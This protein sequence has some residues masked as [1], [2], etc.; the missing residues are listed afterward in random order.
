MKILDRYILS[1]YL[2][3]FISVFTILM[4]IFI[5]QSVW[6]YISEL[7]GKD[8]ELEVVFKFLLYVSPR[9]VVLVLPLT[10]LLASIMVFG[11][12]AENYEFAAMKSTGISL[13]RAMKS[14]SVFIVFLAVISFF[15]ANSV[16]PLAEFNFYSLR[17]N[18]AKVKPAM[19][20]AEGQFNQLGAINIKVAEK[21]GENGEFLKD[22]IIH[23][24]KGSYNGNFTVIKSKTGEFISDESSDVLQLLLFDGNYYDEIQPADY[25]KRTKNR[26]QV[27]ST[28]EKYIINIDA[29]QF[30]DVDFTK[31]ESITK[32]TMLNVIDL[33][34]AIDSLYIKRGTILTNFSNTMLK[35]T[36]QYALNLNYKAIELDSLTEAVDILKLYESRKKIQLIDLAINTVQN[37][38]KD[39][40]NKSKTMLNSQVNINKHIVAF[41]DK[42]ALGLSCIILFFVG[43]PL[44]ALIRKGGI[45]LPLIIAILIF[46]TYHF[47]SLFA[48][49]SSE[50]SSIDPVLAA[51]MSSLILLPFSIYLTSRA[52]KDRALVDADSILIPL[53]KLVVSN[54]DTQLSNDKQTSSEEIRELHTFENEKLIN[55][56]KNFRQY[57]H[58][59][60]YKQSALAVLNSRGI[61][62]L[63]LKMSGDLTN[64]NYENAVQYYIDFKENSKLGLA[65]N[66]ICLVLGLG[67][68]IL[69]NNGFPVVG[70]TFTVIAVLVLIF[71]LI[72]LKKTIKNQSS[73]YDFLEVKFFNKAFILILIG[74]PIFYF[75]RKYFITKMEEDLNK[76]A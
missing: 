6:V 11:G 71:F 68:L 2:K 31:K 75:Y 69:N 25:T 22:V 46:L 19:I 23:Q 12:F 37:A 62:E 20:I 38:K 44:G 47:I 63:E 50:D 74:M 67:G 56:V 7:A 53:K 24:K 16:I 10:I 18:I 34:T 49:N 14:L 43:A 73:F 30:N 26:P 64:L 40:K 27:K 8:L 54:A 55:I 13:Q 21:S 17:R 5:L 48:K 39:L 42:F 35:K 9:I 58:A 3:T 66:S 60:N 4:M 45:G 57:K 72:V 76:I 51:W 52:T 65:L 41:H 59:L 61:S 28:F 29:S 70:K 15:F 36:N 33:N 1:T 32:H